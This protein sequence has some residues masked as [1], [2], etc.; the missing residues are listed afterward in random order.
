MWI[1]G[2]GE[3]RDSGRKGLEREEFGKKSFGKR[4]VWE[5]SYARKGVGKEEFGV[6]RVRR[7]QTTV[8]RKEGSQ[9]K[10]GQSR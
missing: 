4:G 8:C 7:G 10:S 6:G 3:G 1:E 5:K 2:F 9:R